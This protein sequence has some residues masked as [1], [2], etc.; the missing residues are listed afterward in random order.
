MYR[1]AAR[2]R[3][4]NHIY[5]A[6]PGRGRRHRRS[7]DRPARRADQSRTQPGEVDRASSSISWWGAISAVF[8]KRDVPIGAL[9]WT[10]GSDA[11]RR[12]SYISF[13]VPAGRNTGHRGTGGGSGRTELAETLFGLI[14]GTWCADLPKRP[15]RTPLLRDN[16]RPVEL[17]S[18]VTPTACLLPGLVRF[19]RRVI[20]KEIAWIIKLLSIAGLG[21]GA[22]KRVREYQPVVHRL[23]LS[24]SP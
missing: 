18:C 3:R 15:P 24:A 19:R 20:P 12:D 7:R 14:S 2:P 10:R 5:F 17:P 6:P 4:R 13:Q 22:F 1:A 23:R 9:R 21:M 11:V 16:H 8:P